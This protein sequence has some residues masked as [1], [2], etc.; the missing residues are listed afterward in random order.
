MFYVCSSPTKCSYSAVVTRCQSKVGQGFFLSSLFC[1]GS[2]WRQQNIV[3]AVG[4]VL[5]E[6]AVYCHWFML[7]C[8]QAGIVLSGTPVF[9]DSGKAGISAGATLGFQL[10]FCAHHIHVNVLSMKGFHASVWNSLSPLYFGAHRNQ[11]V[12]YCI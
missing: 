4:L 7:N 11:A 1:G 2:R 5:S 12:P 9:I 3:L 10:H 8:K 6:D